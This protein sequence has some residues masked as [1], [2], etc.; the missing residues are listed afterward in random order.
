[1]NLLLDIGNTRIKWALAAGAGGIVHSGAAVHAGRDFHEVLAGLAAAWPTPERVVAC[2]VAGP[3]VAEA[4]AAEARWRW[5]RPV[6]RVTAAAAGH[7]VS[8]AYADPAT[9]GADRWVAM[10]A[11]HALWPGNVL[12]ADCGTAVTVDVV[13]ADGR[14]RGGLIMPGLALM[15]RSLAAATSGVGQHAEGEVVDLAAGTADA[16]HSG[17][18]LMLEAALARA[19]DSARR[20]YGAP[21]TAVITGGDAAGLLARLPGEWHHEPHLV[22]KGLA[23]MAE[24]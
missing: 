8:S 9:L 13:S 2:S 15:R 10:V 21:F 17:T 18:V 22:L 5:D 7:G 1:M 11:A 4:L 19:A 14:H 16:V 24:G 6:Q 23:I 12:V 20:D 3:A